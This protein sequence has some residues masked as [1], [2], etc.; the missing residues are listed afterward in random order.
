MK[1]NVEIDYESFYVDDIEADSPD[2]AVQ[3]A[4]L[5]LIDQEYIPGTCGSE[6][7]EVV[8]G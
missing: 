6:V 4:L 5:E 8:D 1:Y 7:Y 2:E 3:K